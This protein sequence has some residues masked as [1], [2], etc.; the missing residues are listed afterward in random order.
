MLRREG[1]HFYV[2]KFVLTVGIPIR[3]T[4]KISLEQQHMEGGGHGK[5]TLYI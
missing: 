5:R 2:E 3:I 1:F 4:E